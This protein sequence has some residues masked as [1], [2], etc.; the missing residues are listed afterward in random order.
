M[1]VA[2]DVVSAVVVNFANTPLTA[3][4]PPLK[5]ARGIQ[6]SLLMDLGS[7]VVEEEMR[8]VGGGEGDGDGEELRSRS[9]GWAVRAEVV[10]GGTAAGMRGS[11]AGSMLELDEPGVE[12]WSVEKLK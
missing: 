9:A 12:G 2:Q 8:A 6:G 11:A 1:T 3:A 4:Q 5:A 7:G 10:L